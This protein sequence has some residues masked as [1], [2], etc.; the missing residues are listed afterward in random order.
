MK[1]EPSL[2]GPMSMEPVFKM[3]IYHFI[4]LILITAICLLPGCMDSYHTDR[5]V[6]S[7]KSLTVNVVRDLAWSSAVTTYI[8]NDAKRA[9][10]RAMDHSWVLNRQ[11]FR[12]VAARGSVTLYQTQNVPVRSGNAWSFSIDEPR[13]TSPTSR[14]KPA[15]DLMSAEHNTISMRFRNALVQTWTNGPDAMEQRFEIYKDMGPE[16]Q[17]RIPVKTGLDWR[18]NSRGLYAFKDGRLVLT[19]SAPIAFDSRGKQIPAWFGKKDDTLVIF[20][21]DARHYPVYIDPAWQVAGEQSQSSWFGWKV[22]AAGDVNQD[23]FD[24]VVV[25]APFFHTGNQSAGKIYL[26]YGNPQGLSDTP[27]WTSSGDNSNRALFGWSVASGDFN[28]DGYSDLAVGAPSR[29]DTGDTVGKAFVFMGSFNGPV[30]ASWT[31]S[32]DSQ[33]G[34]FFGTSIASAGDTNGDGFDDLLVGAPGASISGGASSLPGKVF[35]FA[36]SA[37][38]PSSSAVWTSTGDNQQGSGFGWSVACAGDVNADSYTDIIIGAHLYD[39]AGTDTG[40]AYLYLGSQTFPSTTP[41]WAESGDVQPGAQF[42]WS[43]SGGAIDVDGYSDLVVSAPGYDAPAASAGRIYAYRG[44][45]SNTGL[46]SSYWWV[47]CADGHAGAQFGWSVAI[48]GDVND[49]GYGEILAGAPGDS[50]AGNGAGKI[51]LFDGSPAGPLEPSS[52]SSSGDEQA[53]AG[54]G[55]SV[56]GAGDVNNDGAADFLVGAYLMDSGGADTGAAYLYLGTPGGGPGV[57]EPVGAD[58]DDH[59]DCTS[60]D[61]CGADGRCHG[62]PFSCDDGNPCTDDVCRP[63]G[64]CSFLHNNL[65]CDDHDPCT[66][67]DVCSAA[68]C[69]GSLLDCSWLDDQCNRGRCDPTTGQCRPQPVMDGTPCDDGDSCT[70]DESCSAGICIQGGYRCGTDSGCGCDTNRAHRLRTWLLAFFIFLFQLKKRP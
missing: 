66:T 19:A 64:T 51:W 32:G 8:M 33:P 24:D 37:S 67:N 9:F 41:A 34:A 42:G 56:A 26:Y 4:P 27:A 60:A 25:A 62:T 57:C 36:G 1:T 54:F 35:L 7:K 3:R 2:P 31:S 14:T 47:S 11:R 39:M 61:K 65:P 13:L 6:S 49:D 43:V 16:F 18:V 55:G 10:Y 40:R 68:Q 52:F 44:G 53:G 17:V 58:C 15:L 5:D 29:A 70:T 23:G 46:G 48:A 30:P 50:E 20:I 38:G 12:A 45:D 22:Q 59:D 28:A 63:G 69:H 21:N